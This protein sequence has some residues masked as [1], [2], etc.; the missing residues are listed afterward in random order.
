MSVHKRVI[1]RG[2][3]WEVRLRNPDGSHYKKRFPTRR[4]ADADA[5]TKLAERSRGN[6]L[7]PRN[8]ERRV[9]DIAREWLASN[10]A[11]RSGTL[12]R[13]E[14]IVR[15]HLGPRFGSLPIGRV[16]PRDVQAAVSDWSER[17]KPRTVRR[18]F[19]V[20][21]AVFSFALE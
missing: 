19:G 18:Q 9:A 12:A 13:D 21:R 4:E 14:G 2:T 16:T 6:W 15:V 7:D 11:K 3:S 5:A 10:P 20:V 17:A 1:K 8:A